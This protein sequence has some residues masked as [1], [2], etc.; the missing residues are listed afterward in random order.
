MTQE[1]RDAMNIK[2]KRYDYLKEQI[3]LNEK[4]LE[5]VKYGGL[6]FSCSGSTYYLNKDT[7]KAT[8]ATF[9]G[10]LTVILEGLKKEFE[11]L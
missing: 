10:E 9:L 3:E 1:E 2:V 5:K 7:Y 11:T 6:S 8:Y 4:T